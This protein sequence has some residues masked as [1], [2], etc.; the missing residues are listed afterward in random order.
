MK[1]PMVKIETLYGTE[2]YLVH[3]MY[4]KM[5]IFQ[6]YGP[7][8][9]RTWQETHEIFREKVGFFK[10]VKLS[11]HIAYLKMWDFK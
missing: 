5:Q 6:F 9:V 2:E 10:R 3:S 1:R 7:A 11:L 4:P 8:N